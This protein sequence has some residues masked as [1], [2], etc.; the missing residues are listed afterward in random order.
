MAAIFDRDDIQPG[1]PGIVLMSHGGLAVATA[2]VVR[3][4]TGDT[5][6][7]AAFSLEEGQEAQAYMAQAWEAIESLP[8]GTIVFT[9]L[10]N[11]TPANQLR[12]AA[13]ANKRVVPYI[14]GFNLPLV[15]AALDLREDCGGEELIERL[16][17][18]PSFGV[19][20]GTDFL[21]K[22]IR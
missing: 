19:V 17:E 1:L 2:D 18:L 4:I 12:M 7:I 6:N 14:A 15:I 21:K 20:N 3:M 16:M 22:H 10:P 5:V 13:Y 8:E 9:D 11:G